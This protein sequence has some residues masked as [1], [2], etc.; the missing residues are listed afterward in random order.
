VALQENL[1][2]LREEEWRRDRLRQ[3]IEQLRAALKESPWRLMPSTTPIQPLLVGDNEA[4]LTLSEVLRARGILV[5][6]IRPP[7]VP[8]GTARLRISL[9]AAHEEADVARLVEVLREIAW[10]S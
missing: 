7:T 5:P 3:L 2:L 4:A 10:N 6:A 8:A 9:S 1:A